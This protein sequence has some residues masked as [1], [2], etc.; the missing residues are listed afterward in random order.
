MSI[1]SQYQSGELAY[2]EAVTQLVNL[3]SRELHIATSGRG[4]N[5]IE[6]AHI[7][8]FAY[9]EA[10][11]YHQQL[12]TIWYEQG[13]LTHPP[14]EPVLNSHSATI[15]KN[16]AWYQTPVHLQPEPILHSVM[17]PD[18]VFSEQN[19]GY[20][21]LDLKMAQLERLTERIAER[22][23]NYRAGKSA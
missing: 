4:M 11:H 3:R 16:T 10:D 8:Q 23:E 12:K 22:E 6:T 1:L 9:K 20:L 19:W 5:P 21:A 14:F 2:N 18:E 15:K 7:R 13:R 17:T